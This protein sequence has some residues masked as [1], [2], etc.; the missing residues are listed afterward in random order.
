MA[1][2]SLTK[3]EIVRRTA[4]PALFAQFVSGGRYTLAPHIELFDRAI[5]D[6]LMKRGPNR[7][8]ITIP[9]RHGKSELFSKY[10]PAW[11]LGTEPDKRVL[12][13]SYGANLAVTWGKKARDLVQACGEP[14]FDLKVALDAA[15][16]NRWNIRGH[17]GGMD[18]AGVDG[19]FTGKGGHLLIVD[20]PFKDA[21]QA[22]SQ[23]YR[24]K[25]WDWWES[26]AFTRLE[27]GGIAIVIQTR[28]H[29]DDLAGRLEKRFAGDWHRINLPALAEKNDPLGRA[30]G[31][32]LFPQRYTRE[33]L[34]KT[35]AGMRE[36]WWAALYQQRPAPE[37]GG[38]FKRE[39]FI[40]LP[41]GP[42]GFYN[43][44]RYWDKAGTHG[45]GDYSAGVLMAEMGGVYW[46][47]DVCRGQWS[48]LER[49]HI[50]KARAVADKTAFGGRCE[51]WI[52][53]EP[54]SG[55]KESAENTI[56]N[57]AGVSVRAEKVTGDKAVRADPFAAQVEGLNVQLVDGPWVE[58]FLQE[59]AM[60]PNGAHDDQID[61]AA[62]AF[63]K[64]A[65]KRLNLNG[66]VPAA[67]RIAR[68]VDP[69]RHGVHVSRVSPAEAVRF[70]GAARRIGG[71]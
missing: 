51:T 26:T 41:H 42:R 48:A 47:L 66:E 20:D 9:P 19:P 31:E 40:V 69:H 67:Q 10:L 3:A 5:V 29:E 63:N 25:V 24:D 70:G 49:E 28:W 59:A 62:G 37:E 68:E 39:H 46:I 60:F 18:T 7:L 2:E 61:A 56:R 58:Q 11:F 55:G 36:F 14:V 16:G 52:E 30:P 50:I 54:G 27:P 13:A 64:L 43:V 53:Q 6:A 71:R 65:A 45:D 21:E 22:L 34:L 15:A 44:I 4:T 12:L 17:E 35:K 57:L 32:A 1:T 8:I 38:L 23:T 33:D